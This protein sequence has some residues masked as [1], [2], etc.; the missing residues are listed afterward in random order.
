MDKLFTLYHGTDARMLTMSKDERMEYLTL[1]DKAIAAMWEFLAP[2]DE[3]EMYEFK[4]PRGDKRYSTRWVVEKYKDEFIKA[5]KNNLYTN[6]TEKLSMQGRRV[7]GSELYQYGDLYLAA[8]Y[9]T[10]K[11]YAARSFAGGELGLIAYRLAEGLVFLNF[12]DWHPTPE[13][14]YA[15]NRI[16]EFGEGGKEDPVIVTLEGID[17]EDLVMDN[18]SSAKEEIEALY[19]IL[20]NLGDLKFRYLKD[21][22]LSQFPIEHL[23]KA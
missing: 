22:D 15:I 12:P 7:N 14:E 18:G 13:I 5:G 19:D 16:L 10:A 20:G 9:N 21:T 1:V 8:S 23:K 6:F 4:G 2:L 17:P 3:W 11:D